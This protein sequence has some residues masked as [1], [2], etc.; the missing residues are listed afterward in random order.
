MEA[1]EDFDWEAFDKELEADLREMEALEQK[2]EVGF[3]WL[4]VFT[5]LMEKLN[6]FNSNME[7]IHQGI[8]LFSKRNKPS[9]NFMNG[10]I[11]VGIVSAY[12][13]FIHDFFH[14]CCSKPGYVKLAVANINKLSD[15]DRNYLRLKHNSSEECLISA[16]K[17]ATLH[18]PIQVA[19]ISLALFDLEMPILRQEHTERLLEQRNLFT[20]HGG[21]HN[22]K[23]VEINIEYVLGVYSVVFRLINGY[24]NAIKDHA[25]HYLD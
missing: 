17:K 10:I 25:E 21:L 19:R 8:L 18:D 16:L 22:G 13:S 2:I 12:E 9:G 23:S 7:S 5:D 4:D 24:I 6:T 14:I 11:L 3:E 20:H 15:K 1:D